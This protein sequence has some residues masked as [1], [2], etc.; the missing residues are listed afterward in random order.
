MGR[1]EVDPIRSEDWP[2][3]A[4]AAVA[5][6]FDFDADVERS[7]RNLDGRLTSLSELRFGAVRGVF[8]ILELLAREEIQATFYVPGM[9]AEAYPE[10]VREIAAAGHEIG[11]HGHA[12][13]FNDRASSRQQRDELTRGTAAL[14]DL[15]GVRPDGY[16]AP[17]WELTP[18]S[19]DMLVEMGFRYD[20]SCMGDDRPYFERNGEHSI[21]ELPVHWS[22]DDWVYFGF[23]R[24][25][26][27]HMADPDV[28]QRVW[29]REFESAARE[30][31]LVTYTLHP[32]CSG[33][34]YR[35]AM[36]A[37]LITAM[38]ERATVWFAT[39]GEIASWLSA[40][41]LPAD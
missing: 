12:H 27:G 22:L 11:H 32:E 35:A 41:A 38:R 9:I 26:L 18:E 7:W 5:L 13:L 29:L 16:R 23:Q 17:G 8:R 40:R 2:N 10:A 14:E 31:R 20:S 1:D 4:S 3:G 33:R 21:L 6:T 24:D 30:R 25:E 19:L 37:D 28:V 15:L 34:A 36:L 39:H